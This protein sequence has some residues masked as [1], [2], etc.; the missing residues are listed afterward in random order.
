M[1]CC[2]SFAH[3]CDNVEHRI[4]YCFVLEVP[5]WS[6]G[7]CDT[8]Q[9]FEG[10]NSCRGNFFGISGPVAIRR[11]LPLEIAGNETCKCKQALM[12]FH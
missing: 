8:M 4:S 9:S 5:R 2:Y 1:C 12:R 6:V 7:S 10:V 3:V 11:Q